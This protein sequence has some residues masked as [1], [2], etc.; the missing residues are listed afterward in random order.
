MTGPDCTENEG[1]FV[2]SA[3]ELASSGLVTP[4]NA[5]PLAAVEERYAIAIS[6]DIAALIDPADPA[7][8]IARQ[9]VP[10]V[11]EL[12]THILERPDPIGDLA[13]QPVPGIVHR[14]PDRVLLQAVKVCPV[15][16]RFCFRRETVGPGAG[17]VLGESELN[18]ACDYIAGNANIWEV[19]LSGGDPLALSPRRI[20]ELML[21]L[22]RIQHVRVVRIHTR[23]PVVEPRR[24][25]P[26]LLAA[27][28][29]FARTVYVAL[30]AN[31]PR[32]IS[33]SAAAAC[34][35][36]VD[37]GIPMVSQTVLLK[38]V[39]DDAATLAELM[40]LF[41]EHRIKPYYLH[42]PDLAPG[43]G[44]FRVSIEAG[45][46]LMR[47][48]RGRLSGLAHPE[49][50]IDIPGGFGKSPAAVAY[51]VND[52]S[53]EGAGGYRIMDWQGVTHAYDDPAISVGGRSKPPRTAS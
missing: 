24:V 35:T 5:S 26:D 20:R 15:Y 23:V 9:F 37:N 6:P 49:Y 8:P 40:R 18:A 42:H 3:R 32:E 27:L 46:E 36:L 50:V 47:Q 28:K 2:R 38:G 33:P 14:Y 31:H 48:L 7:D 19:I 39:N 16:C 30:H 17:Q 43:T 51:V 29:S 34:A 21:R 1:G 22:S 12:D 44:H 45:Q 25:N 11:R 53:L 41:V 13:H 4:E 10:D 52:G